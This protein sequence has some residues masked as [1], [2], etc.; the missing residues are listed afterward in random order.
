MV[1]ILKLIPG[2]QH[3]CRPFEKVAEELRVSKR[4]VLEEKFITHARKVG[5]GVER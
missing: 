2:F 4:L 3:V 1:E 5:R